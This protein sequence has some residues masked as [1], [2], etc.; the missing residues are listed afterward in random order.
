MYGGYLWR[1][2]QWLGLWNCYIAFWTLAIGV[3]S[4]VM[5]R[6][7]PAGERWRFAA[8]QRAQ[9]FCR[10]CRW[11]TPDSGYLSRSDET[12]G[13][14]LARCTH[15]TSRD[16]PARYLVLGE[17]R[18]SDM[19]YCETARDR[20]RCGPRGRYWEPGAQLIEPRRAGAL[21]APK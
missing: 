13:W 12:A 21:E 1:F 3:W 4:G 10:V 20:G 15:P 16:K 18:P 5:W 2:L 11:A 8:P 7:S 9:R 19:A 6:L 17:D 14:S